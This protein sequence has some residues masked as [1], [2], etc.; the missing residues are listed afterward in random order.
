[1]QIE[2]ESQWNTDDLRA[3]TAGVM[4][5]EHLAESSFKPDFLL[6]FKTCR[7]RW[8]SSERIRAAEIGWYRGGLGVNTKAVEIRSKEKLIEKNVLERLAISG[9]IDDGIIQDIHPRLIRDIA[10]TI[11]YALT[12]GYNRGRSLEGYEWAEKFQLRAAPKIT[13]SDEVTKRKILQIEEE[14]ARINRHWARE[15]SNLNEKIARL[16]RKLKSVE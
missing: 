7:R 5:H 16:K 10:E 4:K 14:K 11:S 12:G 3:L 9:T 15:I 2:N 8:Y 1:M 6:I 13:R